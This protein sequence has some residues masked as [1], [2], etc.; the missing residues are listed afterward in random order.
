MKVRKLE[1]P[2]KM[3]EAIEA[4]LLKRCIGSWE[5]KRDF[6]SFGNPLETELGEFYDSATIIAEESVCL[7]INFIADGVYGE[8]HE[9]AYPGSIP[10][11]LNFEKIL[12]FGCSGDGA[13]F[14]LDYREFLDSPSVIWWDDIHWRKVSPNFHMFLELFEVNP[15]SRQLR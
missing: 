10:D 9:E 12:C 1:I 5:L 13:P 2:L 7:G 6:D 4:G 8:M 14:C 11:I 15:M 3:V